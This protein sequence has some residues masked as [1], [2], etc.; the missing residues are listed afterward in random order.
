[1][2][3][4]VNDDNTYATSVMV[5][6]DGTTGAAGNVLGHWSGYSDGAGNRFLPLTFIWEYTVPANFTNKTISVVTRK[7]DGAPGGNWYWN[8]N[9]N[10]NHGG[11]AH[12]SAIFSVEE[13]QV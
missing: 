9:Q 5:T 13:I 1:M 11:D 10:A 6:T 7:Q 12:T 3:W 8:I 2:N 4:H